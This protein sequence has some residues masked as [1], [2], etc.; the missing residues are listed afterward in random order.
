M[1]YTNIR[2]C[3]PEPAR[4][5]GGLV[6]GADLVY[7]CIINHKIETVVS[8]TLKHSILILNEI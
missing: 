4:P 6:S 8:M 5:V 1:Y 7:T 2:H 3:Q